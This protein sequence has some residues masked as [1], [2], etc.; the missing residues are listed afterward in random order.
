MSDPQDQTPGD[1]GETAAHGV[2]PTEPVPTDSAPTPGPT[3][4]VADVPAA[5]PSGPTTVP[6]QRRFLI[7]GSVVGAIA[8]I[9]LAFGAGYLVGDHTGDSGSRH[10]H[11]RMS[12]F[13]DRTD[14]DGQRPGMGRFPG[15]G[16]A[17]GRRGQQNLPDDG[18]TDQSTAPTAPTE[19][20]AIPG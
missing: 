20:S 12:R 4:P 16:E 17:P 9:G 5:Q 7:A 3:G 10:D 2:T 11:P 13:D 14:E 18:H 6:V 19:P 15:P 8:V 1:A